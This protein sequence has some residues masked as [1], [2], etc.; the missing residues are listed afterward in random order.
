MARKPRALD[1][2]GGREAV[3]RCRRLAEQNWSVG[4]ICSLRW[5]G[6]SLRV[7]CTV[8][9][10]EYWMEGRPSQVQMPTIRFLEP[11]MINRQMQ[12]EIRV[13]SDAIVPYEENE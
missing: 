9:A 13:T 6:V 12:I 7:R 4:D 10:I 11:Q 8:V 3:N 5:P 2:Q 1:G